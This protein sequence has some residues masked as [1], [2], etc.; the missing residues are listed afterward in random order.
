MR[1]VVSDTL[2]KLGVWEERAA[3]AIVLFAFDQVNWKVISAEDMRWLGQ[4]S[5]MQRIGP[6]EFS[7]AVSSL[8]DKGYL[9]HQK[10]GSYEV[11]QSLKNL[12]Q[13]VK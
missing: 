8:T 10:N 11:S 5:F 3:Q 4:H 1:V 7:R 2:K 9:I 13:V 12:A 6:E